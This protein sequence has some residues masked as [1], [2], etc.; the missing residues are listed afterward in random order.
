MSPAVSKK[1]T[2]RQMKTFKGR[3]HIH[4]ADEDQRR[5][6]REART[7]SMHRLMHTGALLA[8]LL[9]G[10]YQDKVGKQTQSQILPSLPVQSQD[11][12]TVQGLPAGI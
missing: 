6:R 7:V 1:C 2:Y 10:R 11:K 8:V 12:Q 5:D 9:R 4:E 3:S